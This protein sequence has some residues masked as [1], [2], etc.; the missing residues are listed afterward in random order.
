[1]L[2]AHEVHIY[3]GKRGSGKSTRAKETLGACL[4]AGQRVL[5]WDPHDEYS[6]EGRASDEVV[7]GPLPG[8]RELWE[9]MADP[10]ELLEGDTSF[11]VVPVH[12][13]L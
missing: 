5:V 6:Q 2:L 1:M 11:A 8:H 13:L 9:L 3:A 12:M 7:L 4:K 10:T